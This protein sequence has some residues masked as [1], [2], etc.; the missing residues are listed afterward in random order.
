MSA[1]AHPILALKG[2]RPARL[3]AKNPRDTRNVGSNSNLARGVVYT[4]HASRVLF[5]SGNAARPLRSYLE[6]SSGN[7]MRDRLI[8][9]H[10]RRAL[11]EKV[12]HQDT[13][14]M[15]TRHFFMS[16]FPNSFR[17]FASSPARRSAPKREPLPRRSSSPG[18]SGFPI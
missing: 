15:V 16:Y 11:D 3:A 5:G 8:S 2:G 10:M 6:Y 4:P 14:M 17:E 7:K 9:S 13:T 18:A 1:M 12:A